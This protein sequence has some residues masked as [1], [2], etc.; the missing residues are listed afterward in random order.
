ME[1]KTQECE[2]SNGM[3]RSNNLLIWNNI[4]KENIV[5]VKFFETSLDSNL[6]LSFPKSHCQDTDILFV[7][8]ECKPLKLTLRV[9]FYKTNGGKL[10]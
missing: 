3:R 5:F 8:F 9:I 6:L 1:I 7:L 10:L 4:T 2:R